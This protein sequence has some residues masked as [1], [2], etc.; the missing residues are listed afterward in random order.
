MPTKDVLKQRAYQRKYYQTYPQRKK[1]NNY[2][3]K[4][5]LRYGLTPDLLAELKNKQDNKCLGCG[6]EKSLCVDHCHETGKVRGLLCRQC[7]A[8]IG[9][10]QEDI[11]IL[12]NLVSYLES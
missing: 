11:Q 6:E 7:N 5:K 4:L 2:L 8:A 9:L 12:K 10:A 3:H 1:L